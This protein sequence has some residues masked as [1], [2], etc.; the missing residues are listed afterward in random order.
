MSPTVVAVSADPALT[1]FLA[2]LTALFMIGLVV[3][4]V[5]RLIKNK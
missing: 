2:S 3:S 1:F 4:S 5:L